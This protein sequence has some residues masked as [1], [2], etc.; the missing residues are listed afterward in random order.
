MGGESQAE[1]EDTLVV[2]AQTLES[3]GFPK[4]NDNRSLFDLN[5]F[6][7][8]LTKPH[9]MVIDECHSVRKKVIEYAIENEIKTIGLTATPFTKGLGNYYE[10]IVNTVTT[11]KLIDQG[12]LAPLK[13]V[14][15]PAQVDVESIT[16]NSNGEFDK[17][18]MS[19]RVMQ[20]VG[21]VV[22]EWEKH[23]RNFFGGPVPTIAFYPSVADSMD[24]AEKFQ[25]AGYDFQ[26]IH[27]P[28]KLGG[29][30]GDHRC[31]QARGTYRA[32]LLR[33]PN[34]GV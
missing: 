8:Y 2:S 1:W 5:S 21:D 14:A 27:Y 17:E 13:V 31:L 11:Q 15:P 19:E 18:E 26:V 23:T 20:I 6:S 22:A 16:V 4:A 10:A 32:Y 3:R 9:L 34:Q 24:A 28:A 30:A 25:A 7:N 12:Y 33:G 29:K